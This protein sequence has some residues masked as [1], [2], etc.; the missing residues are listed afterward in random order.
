MVMDGDLMSTNGAYMKPITGTNASPIS[1]ASGCDVGAQSCFGYHTGD[2][3]LNGGSTRFSAIDT[4]ARVSTS[5]LD[6][7]SYSSQPTVSDTTDI[8]YRLFIRSLQDAGLYEARIR[9]VSVPIF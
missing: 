3:T 6:E 8:V 4:Y 7:V 9:Y 2:D 5:T 1:W